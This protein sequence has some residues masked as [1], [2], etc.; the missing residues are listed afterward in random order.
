MNNRLT[1]LAEIMTKLNIE[2]IGGLIH[3]VRNEIATLEPE[4]EYRMDRIAECRGV[5]REILLGC[6]KNVNGKTLSEKYYLPK[7][8]AIA[9]SLWKLD[10]WWI[11][12]KLWWEHGRN[13]TN[14]ILTIYPP[15]KYGDVLKRTGAASNAY[16]DNDST[17]FHTTISKEDLPTCWGKY[18][19]QESNL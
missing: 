13:R 19:R 12:E 7:T 16:T 2:W 14:A 11:E 8:K 17:V 5:F 15:E 3:S 10:R 6:G 18:T 9:E 4:R 1:N